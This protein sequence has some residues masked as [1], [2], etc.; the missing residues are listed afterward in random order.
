MHVI[1]FV[2]AVFILLLISFF[3]IFKNKKTVDF[4]LMLNLEIS[5]RIPLTITFANILFYGK[6]RTKQMINEGKSI[7]KF[8]YA[9]GYFWGI[10]FI[11][12]LVLL[13]LFKLNYIK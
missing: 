5:S 6:D 2:F 4:L 13:V 8:K 3:L 7:Y 9:V 1:L 11:I 12:L 10:L